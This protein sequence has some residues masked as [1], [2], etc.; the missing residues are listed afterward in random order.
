MNIK[1]TKRLSYKQARNTVL[2][3]FLLGLALSIAQVTL[4][5]IYEKAFIDVQI[6]SILDI[7]RNPAARMAYIIDHELAQELVNGLLKSPSVIGVELIDSNANVLASAKEAMYD[8]PYR[9]ISDFLFGKTR[10]YQEPLTIDYNP[11]ELLGYLN[12]E[13]DTYAIGSSFLQRSLTTLATGF[14]RSLVLS[15]ILLVLFYCTLTKPL[16][17]LIKALTQVNPEDEKNAV[18]LPYPKHHEDD[19]IGCLVKTTNQYL[20]SLHSNLTRRQE[21]EAQLRH[22]LGQLETIVD[23]R[24]GELRRTN[25]QLQTSNAMLERARHQAEQMA[26]ARSAFLASMSH[27][28]RTPLNG[29]LGMIGLTLDSELNHEQQQQLTIAYN[30]GKVLVELLN[31]ILD[32]SKFESGKLLLEQ[33]EFDLRGTV[34]DAVNLH[35]QSANEKKLALECDIAPEIPE[36][37]QGD[38]TRIHQVISNLLSNA[39]K[40]TSQGF[41]QL[42]V[43]V[44]DEN[45]QEFIVAINIKDSGIGISK[46]AQE[47]IFQPFSQAHVD[48]TRKYGGTGLGLALCR[49]LSE[50][51]G[52]HLKVSSEPSLGST[53]TVILP[54]A[55]PEHIFRPQI[56]PQ[57]QYYQI[58]LLCHDALQQTLC[59]H[60]NYWGTPY[61]TLNYKQ[62][63]VPQLEQIKPHLYSCVILDRAADANAFINANDDMSIIFATAHQDMLDKETQQ[64]LGISTQLQLPLRRNE[65]YNT[66]LQ[67]F[68]LSTQKTIEEVSHT[69]KPS[70]EAMHILVVEDNHINQLV[71]KG[72]LEKIG[73]HVDVATQGKECLTLCQQHHY[74]LVFMDCNMPVMD[75]YEATQK[76][77]TINHMKSVPVIA[78]TANALSHDRQ[79]CL[80]AG[81]NDYLA[82]PFKKD[83]LAYMVEKWAGQHRNTLTAEPARV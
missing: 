75:G 76:L 6:R 26:E 20:Q 72:M 16:V 59:N 31:D 43:Q 56:N 79:K 73:H 11:N 39:I 81:M 63:L 36:N 48:I 3:A 53:F 66:L 49:N 29:V 17:S 78:L 60:L 65:L 80:D 64:I 42:S 7:T 47:K 40:F 24:T 67:V 14:V 51:M 69:P 77:R 61:K 21:A 22:Y 82:K 8:A 9:G 41:V 1:F 2:V 46:E 15:V 13:I 38:P 33:I 62:P 74:D 50:A 57:L 44:A 83:Q 28:I 54:L 58:L 35:S 71:V 45:D 10:Y 25:E 70:F 27:E 68:H 4:D 55:K 52:G 5:Y 34:E 12:L 37:L 30:S 18:Q 19:E 32:L 23:Q